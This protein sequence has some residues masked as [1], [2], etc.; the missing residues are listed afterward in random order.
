MWADVLQPAWLFSF[1]CHWCV[2]KLLAWTRKHMQLRLV[3]RTRRSRW[4]SQCWWRRVSRCLW[5]FWH[6]AT[7]HSEWCHGR[8]RCESCSNFQ[9]Y[10]L[11]ERPDRTRTEQ[12]KQ[13]TGFWK[14]E[15]HGQRSLLGQRTGQDTFVALCLG[16]FFS[17][18][19][20]TSVLKQNKKQ[21]LF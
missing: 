15:G 4:S 3:Q 19:N 12:W 10:S 8:W 20:C 13:R 11:Y 14:H 5:R 18:Q 17:R 1:C 6:G 7:V 9:S 21:T 2:I 16:F